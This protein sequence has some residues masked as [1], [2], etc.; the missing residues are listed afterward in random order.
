MI[1]P[2][3]RS[4]LFLIEIQAQIFINI[5][6][7]GWKTMTYIVFLH[8]II[9]TNRKQTNN[10]K[11]KHANFQTIQLSKL[12]SILSLYISEI[13]R[14]LECNVKTKFINAFITIYSVEIVS[15]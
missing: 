11:A 1:S 10:N 12:Q 5:L 14:L 2:V 4:Q 15:I 13:V 7:N 3:N 9:A 6:L 8:V